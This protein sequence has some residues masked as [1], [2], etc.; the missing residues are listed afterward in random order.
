MKIG[1]LVKHKVAKEIGI[2]MEINH[3]GD[4]VRVKWLRHSS[5]VAFYP[6]WKLEVIA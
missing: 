1:N 4:T 5:L 6:T 2:A 3:T